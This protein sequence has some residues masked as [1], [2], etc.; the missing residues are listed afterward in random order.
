MEYIT[1]VYCTCYQHVIFT[2]II[3]IIKPIKK[4]K[5]DSYFSKM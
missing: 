1:Q 4:T 5:Q 2:I 3:N